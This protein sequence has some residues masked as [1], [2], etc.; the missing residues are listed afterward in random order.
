MKSDPN[1]LII[2]FQVRLTVPHQVNRMKPGET[3]VV[4]NSLQRG[5]V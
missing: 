2:H 4:L 1:M 5:K 3:I